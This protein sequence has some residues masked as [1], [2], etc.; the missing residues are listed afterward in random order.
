MDVTTLLT[1]HLKDSVSLLA[2]KVAGVVELEEAISNT[3][4]V[5]PYAYVIDVGEV[6]G[7]N[8]NMTPI[9]MQRV[10]LTV[11]VILAIPNGARPLNIGTSG[12][13]NR[14]Q[15]FRD[16]VINSVLGWQPTPACD[17]CTF[18]G[19]KMVSVQGRVLWW[20]D[21]FETAFYRRT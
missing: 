5:A 1:Q 3:K 8:E 18:K 20:Q 2:G 9:I 15:E 21:T 19:G 11:G 7:P 13:P 12:T 16:P 14:L 10:T 6:A 17:P 4:F